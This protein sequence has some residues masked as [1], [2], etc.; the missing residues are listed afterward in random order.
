M[1]C[2]FFLCYLCLQLTTAHAQGHQPNF[3]PEDTISF[4]NLNLM[5]PNGSP[6][7]NAPVVLKGKKGHVVEAI[8]G[9]NGRVKVK[10]PFDET[11]T[12]H[13][14][15]HT[16]LRPITINAFPYVTYNYQAYTRRFIYFTFTYRNIANQRLPNEVV[17]LYTTTGEVFR[18]TTNAEGQVHFYLPFVSEF[19]I[20]VKY[21]DNVKTIRPLD[22][23]K[24]YKI[25]S[26]VFTWMGSKE[27]ERLAH[28]A[29]SLSRLVH[30][31]A[32]HFLDSLVR[33]GNKH[34]IA[35]E[36]IYIPIDYDSVEWVNAMLQI[37]AQ[38]YRE[39]LKQ[40][41]HFFEEKNKA[42][43]A[44]LFRLKKQF[45]HKIV[46]TDITGSMYGYTEQ[47]ILWHALNFMENEDKKYLFFNDGDNKSTSQKRIGS[48]GGFYFCQ[49]QIK[50][51]NTIINT[52]R[53]GM[54][55]G[56]GGEYPEND[57]EALLAAQD[58]RKKYDEV[59]LIADNYSPI[60]DLEL[61]HQLKV[62]IRIILCGVE[63][64][65]SSFWG[66]QEKIINE[67]YLNLA[68][69]T[70]GSIHLIKQDIF[71]LAKTQEGESITIKG[72]KFDFIN[73]RFV[74]QEKL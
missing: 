8:T 32:I 59:F 23:G 71:D 31:D 63:D 55:N 73:G 6:Y 3:S 28:I 52:M 40:N 58:K 49:G 42:V 74:R 11:Y 72:Q 53:K 54:R 62:P 39:K 44:P 35:E 33:T 50:D 17:T 64:G 15:E 30:M 12:V 68:H 57:V 46:V 29:D 51:F 66:K 20:A 61:M 27:K 21:H 24:E 1:R 70:N 45:K 41:P 67:E 19:R 69:A 10:V 2:T 65:G 14:G 25:M 22:V 43:L 56:G 60:R 18:D 37:K 48:T 38:T 5:N 26:T 13:C 36:D 47:V 34:K 16:C 7:A 9:S 4:V